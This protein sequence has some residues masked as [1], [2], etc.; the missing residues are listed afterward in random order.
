MLTTQQALNKLRL[1]ASDS[2]ILPIIAPLFNTLD[3]QDEYSPNR[4][5]EN[6]GY[7][8]LL[9]ETEVSRCGNLEQI[10]LTLS[11][12]TLSMTVALS[13]RHNNTFNS[14]PAIHDSALNTRRSSS[15]IMNADS[16]MLY[17]TNQI[18]GVLLGTYY[19]NEAIS[20]FTPELT[21]CLAAIGLH[22][23]GQHT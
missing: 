7:T 17:E 2:P 4:V 23:Y 10:C 16:H 22:G 19:D 20:R 21:H 9:W 1:Q 15:L 11:R 8:Q 13:H 6:D 12:A 18:N 14:L 3:Y 5:S